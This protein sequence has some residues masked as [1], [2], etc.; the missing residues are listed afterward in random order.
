MFE[1]AYGAGLRAEELVNLDLADVDFDSEQVRVQGKGDR[2]R[3]VPL[4]EHAA[5]A[6]ERYL[7][8]GADRARR[9]R[10]EPER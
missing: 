7:L 3:I 9:R 2:T 8:A 5:A 10:D 4:G 1:L 6:L